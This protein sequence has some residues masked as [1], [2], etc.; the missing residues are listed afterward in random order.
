MFSKPTLVTI[1]GSS[2]RDIYNGLLKQERP[3]DVAEEGQHDAL[4][5]IAQFTKEVF[6]RRSPLTFAVCGEM[7]LNTWHNYF[8]RRDSAFHCWWNWMSLHT[9]VYAHAMQDMVYCQSN[10]EVIQCQ[11]N[12]T[13]RWNKMLLELHYF[14][15][16]CISSRNARYCLLSE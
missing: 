7:D 3:Y 9:N 4:V 10:M 2:I 15:V 12:V 11:I 5:H 16:K 13:R 1:Y 8:Y 14:F 6:L